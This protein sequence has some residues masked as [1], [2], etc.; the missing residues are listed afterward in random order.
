MS[1]CGFFSVCLLAILFSNDKSNDGNKI[2]LAN[3]ANNNVAETKEPNA[4]VPPKLDITNTEKPKN[5]T[6]EV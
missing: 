6:I 4:T 3:I 5:N 1:I 2:K